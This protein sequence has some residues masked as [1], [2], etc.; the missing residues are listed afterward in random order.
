MR[1]DVVVF[2]FLF[3]LLLFLPLII[4]DE[5]IQIDKAKACLTNKLTKD[6][7]CSLTRMSFDDRVFSFL[8][9]GLCEKN[10]SVDNITT[11]ATTTAPSTMCWPKSGTSGC[12]L[13][14]TAQAVLALNE[15]IDTKKA[16]LWLL[17]K[18]ITPP[19]MNWFLQIDSD[20]STAC[21]ITYSDKKY[22]LSMG[23]DKKLSSTAGLGT[24][25]ALTED[26]YWLEIKSACYGLDMYV[27]CDKGFTTSLLF[28]KKDSKTFYVLSTSN[29]ITAKTAT[30]ERV[31]SLCFGQNGVCDY[32]G[33]LWAALVLYRLGYDDVSRFMPYLIAMKDDSKNQQ[34][35]PESF[36][37]YLTGEFETELLSKHNGYYW[38]ESN[39]KYYDTALGLWP[40]Y[41]TSEDPVQ[42]GKTKSWLLKVQGTDGCWNNGNI[43]DTAF[44]LYAINWLKE[45]PIEPPEVECTSDSQCSYLSGESDLYC[46]DDDKKVYKDVSKGNC[47]SEEECAEDITE[48]LEETCDSTTEICYSGECIAKGVP[49]ECET[50]WE[51]EGTDICEDGVCVEKPEEFDCENSDYF[52]MSR[53]DCDGNIL[54]EYSSSC[55]DIFECCDTEKTPDTCSYEGGDIC[56]SGEVCL[57][58]EEVDVSDTSIGE[59]CCVDG[60]CTASGSGETNNTCVVNNG[61]CRGSCQD[62]EKETTDYTCV[63][64]YD[65]CCVKEKKT[66][67]LLIWILLGLILL[68]ALGI[69]FRDKLRVGWL[70]L[71]SKFE[72]KK[73]GHR[74]EMPL[75]HLESPQHRILPRR[76]LPSH[77]EPSVHRQMQGRTALRKSE[78]KSKSELDDVLKKLKEMG[79]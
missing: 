23:E 40:F 64:S 66:G 69:V 74:F 75:T 71:K 17:N 22:A 54:N 11:L 79:K 36:L 39:D 32:E 3:F 49:P 48:V 9:T 8:A 34:Y 43:R 20:S 65:V 62:D 15:K 42:E 26:K 10:V 47:N 60:I 38:D 70:K 77:T 73:P 6:Y 45:L 72:K 31:D 25:L 7:N 24:C 41:S 13:K 58:G 21:T 12:T 37:Y 51:C 50:S 18:N 63:D 59:T 14:S 16:E 33:S 56:D 19:D 1:K 46:S 28:K 2:V 57:G 44:I 4:A 53:A 5:K 30:I 78:D 35:L 52:C 27:S 55:M 68:A 29:K 76:I 61:E 67:Y